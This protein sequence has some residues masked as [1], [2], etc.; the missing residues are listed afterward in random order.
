MLSA[1]IAEDEA[2]RLA[3]LD[4]LSI[5]NGEPEAVFDRVTA[6][7]AQIFGAPAAMMNLID[8]DT[9]YV[10]SVAGAPQ[11]SAYDRAMPRKD[12]ICGHVVGGNRVMV[13]EDLLADERFRDN[14][15]VKAKGLRF[16]AGAPLQ[17]DT[18]QPV[19]ALCVVDFKPRRIS[20]REQGLLQMVADALMTEVKL[21]AASR[22]LLDRNRIIERD[23]AAARIVQRFL[24]PPQKQEAKGFTFWHYY[25]PVD[26]IGGDFLD[27]HI[28]KP[29]ADECPWGSVA[30]LIADVSGHG[31]SAALTSAMVKTS[32]QQAAAASCGPAELLTAV[33]RSLSQAAETGQFVTAA[34]AVYEA[35]ER[36]LH[37][38]SAGHPK[39][40]L[41]RGGR[42]RVIDS[43]NDLPLLIEP[44][45]GYDRHTT[46][47]LEPG[48]RV[49]YYTD[50]A[51][52]AMDDMGEL[53]GIE[54]FVPMIESHAGLAGGEF[55][56]SLFQ[57][58]RS[59]ALGKLHDDVALVCLEVK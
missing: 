5:I 30:L 20:M 45:L 40:V 38:A 9:Q 24:L 42:G 43:V 44:E 37:L 18:G 26:A 28:R 55:L 35:G 22:K 33:Q 4:K 2:D 13:V 58:I 39:P 53:L 1:P 48:D 12:S 7:L 51:T 11:W 17:T 41:L 59:Y 32:F 57:A 14:P 15:I 27:T 23:L 8:A 34:A 47:I 46:Q 36:A 31:A 25:H 21:R 49:I 50:G 10:K 16:Y 3:E 56:R 29:G 54:R 6:E 52:E 19:G